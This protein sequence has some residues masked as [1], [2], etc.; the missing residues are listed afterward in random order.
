MRY[1]LG[2]TSA[3]ARVARGTLY[4]D[5]FSALWTWGSYEFLGIHRS[6]ISRTLEKIDDWIGEPSS[7][8][9]APRSLY[10]ESGLV[11]PTGLALAAHLHRTCSATQCGTTSGL[12]AS[13]STV[14][15][16]RTTRYTATR[17]P[18]Q[19]PGSSAGSSSAPLGSPHRARAALALRH[20]NP[21]P[22]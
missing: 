13:S 16:L 7:S 3:L 15:G 21:I 4:V 1:S 17:G 18:P 9:A 12:R 20:K 8:G 14:S 11:G 2:T 22:S 19:P 10:D 6:G 5:G